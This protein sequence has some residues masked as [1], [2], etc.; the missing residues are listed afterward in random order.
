MM[1]TAESRCDIQFA[2]CN[3]LLVLTSDIL[4]SFEDLRQACGV[5]PFLNNDS[6]P[7]QG[8]VNA[9]WEKYQTGVSHHQG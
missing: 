1:C 9:E 3:D 4:V 6:R 8:A 5:L 7:R 2:V